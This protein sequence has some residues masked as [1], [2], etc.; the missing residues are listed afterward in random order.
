VSRRGLE[1]VDLYWDLGSI[2]CCFRY[3]LQFLYPSGLADTD[4][5]I[6]HFEKT[7][8]RGYI[9]RAPLIHRNCVGIV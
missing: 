5:E 7:L 8:I 9:L 1:A 3:M 6:R 4:T 2:V